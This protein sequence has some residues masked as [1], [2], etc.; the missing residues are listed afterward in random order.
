MEDTPLRIE[1]RWVCITTDRHAALAAVVSSHF[2]EPGVYFAV[3]EFPK[4]PKPY[5]TVIDYNADGAFARIL[6]TRAATWINNALAAIQ[7]EGYL[8]LG[9]TDSEKSYLLP[10]LPTAKVIDVNTLEDLPQREPF[11]PSGDYQLRCTSAEIA[12]GLL[13]AKMSGKSLFI[14]EKAPH[15]PTNVQRGGSGVLVMESECSVED[16]IAINYAFAIGADVVLVPPVEKSA[17]QSLARQLDAWSRDRSSTAFAAARRE[18]TSRLKDINFS[19][20]ELATFLTVGLP[21]GLALKNLIPCSH[22]SKGPHCGLFMASA[23]AEELSPITFDTALVFSPQLFSSEETADIC[24]TLDRNNYNV[25]LL[26]DEQATVKRLDQ[27]GSLLPYDVLHICSH[28][29]ETTGTIPC[30]SS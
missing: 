22:V 5:S 23:I 14:D 3:F 29:G 10:L 26:L 13:Q 28:G 30:W 1:T 7:P 17:I 6:G 2:R 4:T 16:V 20:Y 27:V 12:L 18:M 11:V 21:Y 24:E 25:K 15:L 19:R 9:L 8:L